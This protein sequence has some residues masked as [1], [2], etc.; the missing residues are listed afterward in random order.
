MAEALL[1]KLRQVMTTGRATPAET[2]L[3][4]SIKAAGGC[5]SSLRALNGSRFTAPRIDNNVHRLP[6]MVFISPPS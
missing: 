5:A 3:D 2:R 6:K 1:D 4:S